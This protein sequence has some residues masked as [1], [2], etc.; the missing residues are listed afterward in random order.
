MKGERRVSVIMPFYD[1]PVD[2][3]DQAVASV[4]G[5]TFEDWELL[6][7]DDG[8]TIEEV[9]EAARR[10]AGRDPSRIRYLQHPAFEN[11]GTS[12]SRRLALEACQGEIVALLDSDDIW[13]PETLAEQVAILDRHPKAGVSYGNVLYWSSWAGET[14]GQEDYE[15]EIGVR[16]GVVH[17]GL[18]LLELFIRQ[19]IAIPC[20]CSIAFR[21]GLLE[22]SDAFEPGNPGVY[23]DQMLY[24]KVLLR[25]DV[26]VSDRCWGRYRQHQGSVCKIAEQRG[27]VALLHVEY[28]DWLRRYLQEQRIDNPRLM[29][30]IRRQSWLLR[31]H[32]WVPSSQ[33][34]RVRWV[35]KWALRAAEAL[36]EA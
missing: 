11:R 25:T 20:P 15:P 9:S 6:L 16:T 22:Q 13:P 2:F 29:T 26:F 33:Y 8:S 14:L 31:R 5:Q 21:R 10:H 24:A 35:K 17:P 28:L 4:L 30:A 27:E 1:T 3:L 19:R 32:S 18:R 12:A 7:V 23:E 36:I 34:R